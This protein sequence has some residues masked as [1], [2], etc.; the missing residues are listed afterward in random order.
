MSKRKNQIPKGHKLYTNEHF[1]PP[2][3]YILVDTK[4]GTYNWCKPNILDKLT[5]GMWPLVGLS[6]LLKREARRVIR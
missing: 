6:T 3:N 4:N 2:Y 1:M 5:T